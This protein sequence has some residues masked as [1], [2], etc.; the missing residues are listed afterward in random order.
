VFFFKKQQ[1]EKMEKIRQGY[2]G[3]MEKNR[4]NCFNMVGER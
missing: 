1:E 2:T 3:A 4:E